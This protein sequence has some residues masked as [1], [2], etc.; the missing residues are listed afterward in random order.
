VPAR[1]TNSSLSTKRRDAGW[2]RRIR[3]LFC[4]LVLHPTG[5]G[6]DRTSSIP[7]RPVPST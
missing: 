3:A 1:G 7:G 6:S 4:S 5:A 2:A